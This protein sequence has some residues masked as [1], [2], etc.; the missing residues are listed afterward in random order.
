MKKAIGSNYKDIIANVL[1]SN[2]FELAVVDAKTFFHE[3]IPSMK[4]WK[5]T[6]DQ[7]KDLLQKKVL[8]IRGSQ[9][10]RKISKERED[11]LNYWLPQTMTISIPNAPHM[12]QITNTKEVVQAMDVFLH[13]V[14]RV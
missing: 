11:L 1:P 7:T 14:N 3:E 8:H 4:S 2:S 10:A 9:Q 13:N 12:V 5:F 6:K